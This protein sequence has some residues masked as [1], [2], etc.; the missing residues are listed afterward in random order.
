M[1]L[2]LK[3]PGLA[4][5][6]RWFGLAAIL[7]AVIPAAHAQAF[8]HPGGLNSTADFSRMRTEVQAGAHPWIDSWNLLVNNYHAQTNYLP[9]AVPILQ[10]GNGAGACLANDT[11]PNAMNDAAAVY[12]LALRWEITGDNNFANTATNILNQWSSVCTNLCGDPNVSLLPLYGYQFACGAEILRTYSGWQAADF[13]RFQGWMTNLWYPL[14]NGFLTGHQGTCNTYIWANWD[15]CNMDCLEAIGVLCDNRNIYDQALDYYESGAGNGA[16]NQVDYYLHPGYLG[17]CEEAGRDQGHCT[18]D[19]LLLGV[20]CE[21][22]W[23]QGDDMYGYNTNELLAIS[24]YVCKYNVQP[25]ANSVPF[26]N[27]C[28]CNYDIQNVVSPSSRGTVRPGY[29][30]IYNHYVNLKGLSAP[31]TA[32]MALQTRPEGGG[33]NYGSTSGGFDQLGFTTLT[34]SRMPIPT[35][36]VPAPGGLMAQV[37]NNAVTLS[38]WGS[39]YAGSYNL[40]RSMASG[41]PYTNLATGLT[42]DRFYTDVGLM[43]G[44]RYY[45]VVSAIIGGVETTNSLPVS[46]V[47]NTQLTGVI[48]GS[49]GSY[50]NWN[51]TSLVWGATITNVYDGALG[52]FYDAA[53]TSGAWAGLDLGVNNVIT[54]INYCPRVGFSSRMVGGQFQ[55]AN[56]ADFSSGVVTLFTIPTAPADTWPQS[57]TTQII[58]NSKAFRYVRYLGPANGSC[59]VSEVQFFGYPSPAAA[60]AA[61]MGLTAMPGD[62]QV[63]LT[64]AAAA[65]ATSFNVLRSLVSG[66]PYTIMATGLTTTAYLDVGL[67]DFTNYYYV[68]TAMNAAGTS[69]DS[70]EAAALP[71]SN[72]VVWSGATNGTWDVATT[73]NWLNSGVPETFQN[74]N[75]AQFDDT[76]TG[77]T[78]VNVAAVVAPAAVVITN[79]GKAYV[80][81]S[82]VGDG[83]GGLAG[84]TKSGSG[85]VTFSN[86]NTYTGDLVINGGTVIA[87]LGNSS[88]TPAGTVLGASANDRAVTVNTGGTLDFNVNGTFGGS[89]T[90]INYLP[91]LVING[92]LVQITVPNTTV[93]ALTLNGGTLAIAL[94][95]NN[96]S[97]VYLP[98]NLTSAGVTVGGTNASTIKAATTFANNGVNLGTLGATSVPFTVNPTGGGG[99]DLTVAA[100][101]ANG[102]N[103][104][105]NGLVPSGLTKTGAGTLLLTAANTYSGQTTV[106]NGELIVSTAF[107]GGGSFWVN[108]G[109]ALGITNLS[110]TAAAISNLVLGVSGPATLE[111]QNVSNR[112]TALLIASNVLLNGSCTLAITGTSHLAVGSTYPLLNYAGTF[113]G[114]FANWQLQMP[115]GWGGMLVSNVH[116]VALKVAALPVTPMNLTALPGDSQAVVNWGTAVYATGYNVKRSL[117]S[118]G[119]YAALTGNLL[120]TSFTNTGLSNGTVYYYVVAATNALYALT[121][122]NSTEVGVRPVSAAAPVISATYMGGQSQLSWPPDHI[123]WR[124]QTETNLSGTNWLTLANSLATNQVFEPVM[125]TNGSMFFRLVYP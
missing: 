17:Q 80:F 122:G 72:T 40:K 102:I 43:P 99:P 69:P 87:A 28:D 117:V 53:N 23:N 112:T 60:P 94:A 9:G 118:G 22:A 20:F 21:I 8:T 12:Q 82:T 35:N 50:T 47:P 29:D 24:E 66:G 11:Y 125:I 88:S 58:S 7:I 25:L 68:V 120:S 124:L 48:L 109:A 56:V 116:Q 57:L 62:G 74:G 121:S 39:A 34:H 4:K 61:P 54:Q 76:A 123:G 113:T 111:F 93:G 115:A 16:A 6:L 67:Q 46:A 108:D 86:L 32:L 77:L 63:A 5:V 1:N 13:A 79:S 27:F 37:R 44:T 83:I 90:A 41:G 104:A 2:R 98:L 42:G 71:M 95:A 92:G 59:N 38:W 52:S 49:P 100:L 84:L 75:M 73:T 64:W 85:T 78:T 119:P 65:T 14:C 81:N 30:L 106:S 97:S 114:S 51:G 110:T 31:Y 103:A 96:N 89:N 33:G 26:A 36:A 45:Y 107:A 55:G 19:P 101:L 18:L 3:Y 91:N 105:N 10:R 15:L 70:T